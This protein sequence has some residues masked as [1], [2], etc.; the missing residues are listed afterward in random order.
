MTEEAWTV[1]RLLR[2]TSDHFATK[3][4]ETA[5]LDAEVLLAHA[6][7]I[8]RLRLY[9]D[10]EKPVMEEERARFR[11][12]VQR[13]GEERVPVAY[14]TGRREFWSMPLAVTPDVLIPNRLR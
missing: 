14:L 5:R 4:I 12:L 13:R 1:L 10:F 6:L 7:G 11:T 8:E 9:L 3:G 2:W